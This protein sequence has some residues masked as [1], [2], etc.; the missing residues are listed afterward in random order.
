M[1]NPSKGREGGP[2]RVFLLVSFLKL[3]KERRRQSSRGR[4][5]GWCSGGYTCVPKPIRPNPFDQ[6]PANP[7]DDE[8]ARGASV[9]AA[10]LA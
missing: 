3:R 5:P 8:C 7:L 10:D 2:P 1:C 9:C 6:N 4:P